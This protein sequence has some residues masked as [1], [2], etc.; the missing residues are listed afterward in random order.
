LASLYTDENFRLPVVE[1]LRRLGHDV[2]TCQEAGRAGSGIGDEVVLADALALGRIV[3]TQN[4]KHFVRLHNAGQPP[5]VSSS[6]PTTATR[7][8]WL[9]GSMRRCPPRRP[10]AAGWSG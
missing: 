1:A 6:A 9:G 8:P 2:L 3:L 5:A 4:R 7:R 10:A